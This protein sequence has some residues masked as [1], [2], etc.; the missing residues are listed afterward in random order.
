MVFTT[1]LFAVVARSLFKWSLLATGALAF[2]LLLVDLSFWGANLPKIPHGGWFPLVVAGIIFTI[3]TTWKTGRRILADR[4]GQGALPLDTFL[5]SIALN[6]PARVPGTAVFMSGGRGTPP[7]LLHNLKHNKV[8]HD[9]LIVLTV[10][11]QEVPYVPAEKRFDIETLPR[12]TFRVLVRYGFA[13]DPDVP[14]ALRLCGQAGM[15]GEM[16]MGET[17][18]FLGRE[19]LIPTR[20]R[21]GMAIWRE[22]LFATMSRNAGRATA[23]FH[24]PPNRVVELGAQI[25]L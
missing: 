13:E 20:R 23:Y 7:A 17:S 10:E 1:I 14:A 15:N 16:R 5:E 11:I 22:R 24:I 9:R 4:L 19:T 25:E 18:F 21:K 12:N 8:L 3:M 2:T 6:P